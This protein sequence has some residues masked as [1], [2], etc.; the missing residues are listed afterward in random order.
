DTKGVH[1]IALATDLNKGFTSNGKEDKI[2]VFD[3][4]TL[5]V[6][7]KVATT[8]KNP[9]A[10]VYDP[11]SQQV[12]CFNGRSANATILDAKNNEV[13]GTMDLAGKPE[14][15]VVDGKGNLYVNIEDKN[16]LCHINT[17]TRK[18]E[19][20]WSVKPGDE[21]SGLALDITSQRL[22]SVC[23]NKLMIIVDAQNGKIVGTAPIGDRVDGAGTVVVDTKTH[24]I[25]LPTAD[26]GSTAVPTTQIPKPRPTIKTGSFVILDIAPLP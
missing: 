22:F 3:L 13:V 11:C 16:L 12:F 24:H 7:A 9:D 19:Q 26:L 21:P 6:L 2:T 10:I 20:T 15:A 17:K 23:G 4:K 8:G 25:F 14:F 5:A 1:G 18:M